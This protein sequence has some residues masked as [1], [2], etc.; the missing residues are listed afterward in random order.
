VIWNLVDMCRT[1]NETTIKTQKASRLYC[2][3]LRDR[4]DFLTQ[5]VLD[6]EGS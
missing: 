3:S 6:H 1:Q 5:E 4:R 2:I